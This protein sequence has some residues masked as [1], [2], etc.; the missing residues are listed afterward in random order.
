MDK[1]IDKIEMLPDNVKRYFLNGN[2]K[3]CGFQNSTAEYCK[4]R[5]NWTLNSL[6]YNACNFTVFNFYNP[7]RAEGEYFIKHM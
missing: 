1:Y 3:Y 4:Y 5:I 2:C 6:K 7:K